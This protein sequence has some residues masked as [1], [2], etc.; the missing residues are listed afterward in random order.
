MIL[1]TIPRLVGML[2]GVANVAMSQAPADTS[3]KEPIRDNSF[4]VEEAFNQPAGVVQHIVTLALPRDRSMAFSFS[5]EWPVRSVRH[6]L[7]YSIPVV[8]TAAGSRTGVGDVGL[9]YRYQLADGAARYWFAAP[10]LSLVLPTGDAALG[11]GAGGATIEAMLPVSLELPH[12][13]LTGNAGSAITPAAKTNPGVE[14]RD[15]A[16]RAGGSAIWAFT[17]SLNFMLESVWT[18]YTSTS[19]STQ[20]SRAH[21][22]I[23]SPGV[24]WAR[25]LESGMQIV[26]GLA[27][28]TQIGGNRERSVFVYLSVEHSFLRPAP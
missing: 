20:V 16:L 25:D 4:L 8:R 11:M 12:L 15:V 19:G 28:P 2:M 27:F 18:R 5:Q 24:R 21:E 23:I 13:T 22:T 7:S 1:R 9:H 26:P 3:A 10:R 17:R 6:Q 14:T